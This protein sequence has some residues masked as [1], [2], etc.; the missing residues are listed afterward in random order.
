MTKQRDLKALLC[1]LKVLLFSYAPKGR[2]RSVQQQACRLNLSR[3]KWHASRVGALLAIQRLRVSVP[4]AE[5]R[6]VS[7]LLPCWNAALHRNLCLVEQRQAWLR[8]ILW[9]NALTCWQPS[10]LC[11]YLCLA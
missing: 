2:R 5:P 3:F 6:E 4:E 10:T 9:R 7:H 11:R 1:T 8:I